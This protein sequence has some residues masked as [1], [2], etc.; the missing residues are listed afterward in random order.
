MRFWM[1]QKLLCRECAT[2]SS[3]LL[4]VYLAESLPTPRNDVLLFVSNDALEA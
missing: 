3:Y 2:L 4:Q 1:A